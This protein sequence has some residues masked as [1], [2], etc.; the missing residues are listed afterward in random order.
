[1]ANTRQENI[2]MHAHGFCNIFAIYASKIKKLE[3]H[4]IIRY[5]DETID[6][7]GEGFPILIH[8]F[9]KINDKLGFDA[10]GF[11]S[12]E[13][14]YNDYGEPDGYT[15]FLIEDAYDFLCEKS[16]RDCFGTLSPFQINKWT[17]P[18]IKSYFL[19]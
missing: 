9:L 7:I 19:K 11:R 18:L 17:I 6:D 12:I 16:T 4:A 5:S 1:M 8:A 14:I 3:C 10:Y 2:N 13:K 15:Y